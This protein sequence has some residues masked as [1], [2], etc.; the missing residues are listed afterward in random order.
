MTIARHHVRQEPT[1]PTGA[2]KSCVLVADGTS[3]GTGLSDALRAHGYRVTQVARVDDALAVAH[4]TPL[5]AAITELR[6]NGECGFQLLKQLTALDERPKVVVVTAFGSVGLALQSIQVG[7][8]D[9]LC[10][11]VTASQVLAAVGVP[12]DMHGNA[13]SR[14]DGWVSLDRASEQYIRE[15]LTHFGSV[16]GAAR[17]LGVDRRSLRRRL[18]RYAGQPSDEL[19]HGKPR[20]TLFSR[21]AMGRDGGSHG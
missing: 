7:A 9:F 15:T 2:S 16:A 18:A 14:E 21:C 8:R 20:A 6:L 19:R 1:H 11:P 10:K 17:V 13:V 4:A 12:E 5:A 3:A